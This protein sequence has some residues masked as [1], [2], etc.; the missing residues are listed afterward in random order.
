[1]PDPIV[2]TMLG[3]EDDAIAELA[4]VLLHELVHAN[5]LVPDQAVFNESVASFVGD[6]LTDAYLVGRF[7]AAAPEVAA[8]R[9]ERAVASARGDRMA[10]AYQELDA[11][12]RSDASDADKRA[13]KQR[14][15]AAL[16][17]ELDLARRPN[18]AD[19]TAY[20]TY[21]AGHDAF[22]ALHAA[23]GGSWPRF[24][25]AVRAPPRGLFP[26]RHAKQLDAVIRALTPRCREAQVRSS[27]S[28][29][30]RA[31]PS[32]SS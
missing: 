1:L 28:R 8:Y 24:L 2:S 3:P 12:Y 18:N 22:A 32:T 27:S 15:T 25:A 29:S 20:R 26:E 5:V 16:E 31:R 11:L 19:L 6:R 4:G 7:G 10:R 30:G 21:H 23:C 17:D 9:A 14:V 13:G